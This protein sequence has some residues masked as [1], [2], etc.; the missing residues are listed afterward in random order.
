[1]SNY[2]GNTSDRINWDNVI[3]LCQKQLD[4]ADKNTVTSV[5]DRSEI[6]YTDDSKLLDS[7]RNVIGTWQKAGYNLEEIEWYDY[8]PGVHFPIKVQNIFSEIVQAKPLRVFISEVWPGKVV[9]YHWDVE[10]KESEWLSLY[11][12]LHRYV[13]C[14]DKPRYGSV[15]AFDD[16]CFYYNNQGD[17]YEW[18]NYKDF[19]STANAGEYPS[20]YFHFL[21]YKE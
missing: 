15:L 10:D 21:G 8:Y 2:I 20:Y 17:V 6:K 3:Q 19:H 4:Q 18:K 7:Y 11:G 1:M 13:C 5:I 12:S 16:Y 14:I 9:P